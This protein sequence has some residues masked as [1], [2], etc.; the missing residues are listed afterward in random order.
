[1]NAVTIL[2]ARGQ[3]MVRPTSRASALVGGN[4]G[5][6]LDAADPYSDHMA[7][8]WPYL[9]S[10]DGTVNAYRDTIVARVR[11]IVRNDG[12]AS[13]TITRILDNAV[14]ANFR[15][16][17][18]P[19]FM[20][21]AAYS[22]N[23]AFD[24]QWAYDFAKWLDAAYRSWALGR[25]RWSDLSRNLTVPQMFRLGFR[26][27]L[28]DGDA[29]FMVHWRPDRIK[30]GKASYGT[31]LQVIDPD[32]LSNPN[33]SFDQLN[34]RGGVEIDDDGVAVAYHIRRAH[35]GDIW[36]AGDSMRW[37]RIERETD[38]GRPIIVHDYDHDQ[39]ATHRGGAG[40]L[41]PVL[42]RLRM[43]FQY[44]V[45]ELDA[46]LL[47]AIFS[48]YIESPFD[49]E[50]VS[51]A[52]AGEEKLNAYQAE[53]TAFHKQHRLTVPGS[54]AQMTKLFP[55]EKLGQ[56]TAARP[57]ANFKEF[58]AAVLRNVAAAAG[59]STQQV[60]NNWAD[61]N[62]SSHQG[63]LQEFF[64]TLSRRRDDYASGA[65]QP[66]REAFVEEA[67]EMDEPP[68]PAGAP[69]FEECGG[70]YSRAQW[71]GPPR[72]WT[73]P[74]DEVKGAVLGMDAALMDYDQLCAEQGLDADDMIAA[75]KHT[76]RRFK[77]AGIPVPT[78]SGMNPMGEPASKTI[79]D[80]E[81][82]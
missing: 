8:W 54:G 50:F 71:I 80:P 76:I 70:A 2:D 67:M 37:D 23:S 51:G 13:G 28:I 46:S 20:A 30:P 36:A 33:V 61:V 35:Q 53:R 42:H 56:V 4:N 6:P 9:T 48:A 17:S 44:D 57:N 62:Y 40:I 66:I 5:T 55:G 43:L 38:W 73:N 31:T 59:V 60:S 77:D 34:L 14:G 58:E 7:G 22:G 79:A 63:A 16:I 68:L 47:N 15:P 27:K 39:A 10:A 52:L 74:V 32:R 49:D 78:W 12:W 3:P 26:H 1:V 25:G 81:A 75:R 18:K 69:S 45:A 72:G 19:D 11:D 21:L 64:K 65:C 82:Q 29:L 41:T 24:E